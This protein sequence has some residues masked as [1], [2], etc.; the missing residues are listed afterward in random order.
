MVATTGVTDQAVAIGRQ[1]L[2][3]AKFD[4]LL[5]F[6]IVADMVIKPTLADWIVL[7]VMAA[8]IVAG[9][10]LFIVPAVRG[11]A[12]PAVAVETLSP[13]P[14][15]GSI[16][17]CRPDHISVAGAVAPAAAAGYVLPASDQ[18]RGQVQAPRRRE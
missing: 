2:S 17:G 18:T 4:F 10:F 16:A 7:V 15:A 13:F 6:T 11:A 9:A 14:P 8:L 3:I 12:E 5:L 1:M